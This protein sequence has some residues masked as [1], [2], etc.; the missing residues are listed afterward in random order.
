MLFEKKQFLEILF[1]GLFFL[2]ANQNLKAA[3][4]LTDENI[5]NAV[6]N[7]LRFNAAAPS[8]LIDVET[9]EGIVK[10]SGSVSNLLFKD[11]SVKFAR[12]VKGV[13]GVV[14][15]ITVNAPYRADESFNRY[16]W[17]ITN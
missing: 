15:H 8:Y 11:H 9:S 17:R 14:D 13:R 16:S 4:E 5:S 7:E 2:L 10:L 12:T 6:D 3:N 1:L